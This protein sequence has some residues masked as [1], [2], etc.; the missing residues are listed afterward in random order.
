MDNIVY[1]KKIK[2]IKLSNNELSDIY[3]CLKNGNY[4]YIDD[5]GYNYYFDNK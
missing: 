1:L 3:L 5:M 4:C 2:T